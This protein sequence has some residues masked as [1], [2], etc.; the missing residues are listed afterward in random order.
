MKLDAG[1]QEALLCILCFDDTAGG[2]RFVAGLLPAK[3]FDP[4][5]RDIAERACKYLERFKRVPGEHTLDL[6]RQ[7]KEE[8][9]DKG[10][11]FERLYTSMEG[12]KEGVNREY[13][14]S[15]AT[16]FARYQRLRRGITKSLEAL[17][18]GTEEAVSKAEELL[19]NSARASNELFDP[20][21]YLADAGRALRFLEHQGD[22][23]PT[24]IKELDQFQ[25]GPARKKMHTLMAPSNK[26]KSWW[27][28][29]AGVMGLLARERVVHI[30]N[31]N[32]EDETCQ[33]YMMRLF[34]VSKRDEVF[35]RIA[36]K[37]NKLGKM[38]KLRTRQ[39]KGR[40]YFADPN[41]GRLLREK[42]EL[43]KH[44]TP[45]IIKHFPTGHLTMPMLEGYLSGLESTGFT[46]DTLII[47][48][49]DNF[50]ISAKDFRIE[51]G[52]LWKQLRG[53]G[54]ERNL[55]LVVTTQAN[56]ASW[57]EKVVKGHRV[58]E[59]VSKYQTS[60]IVFTLSSTEDEE[61]LGLARIRVDKSRS[62]IKNLTVLISQAYGIGQFVMD[63]TRMVN[64]YWD[65]VNR[66]N[67]NEEGEDA[68]A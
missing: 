17:Q 23:L 9:P 13:I 42:L 43:F 4:F 6:V 58:G 56:R 41:I 36:F 21:T 67:G 37:K 47:D 48:S 28:V 2:G 68:A 34:S 14:L 30:T 60:D 66:M 53:L 55:R 59:D 1:I 65:L 24:G 5:Y 54:Q 8:Q 3:T 32:D 18:E 38:I 39:I 35:E 16:V 62:D 44:R 49:P 50:A 64:K 29:N 40:P 27:V 31:E 26:G 51:T 57:T 15:R 20:G 19:L 52:I 22:A 45:L 33:R 61:A 46:P 7:L 63:S 25:L 12:T 10:E 11:V